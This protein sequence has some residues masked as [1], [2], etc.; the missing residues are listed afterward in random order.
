MGTLRGLSIAR[1]IEIFKIMG[2]NYFWRTPG[3]SKRRI[4]SCVT[5]SASYVLAR[6]DIPLACTAKNVYIKLGID[7]HM[8]GDIHDTTTTYT[9]LASVRVANTQ[10]RVLVSMIPFV[11]IVGVMFFIYGCL[12][13]RHLFSLYAE[14]SDDEGGPCGKFCFRSQVE[15]YD[16][17]VRIRLHLPRHCTTP[18]QSVRYL[19]DGRFL[20]ETWNKAS[21]TV[22]TAL[23]ILSRALRR[24]LHD[25]ASTLKIVG[26]PEMALQLVAPECLADDTRSTTVAVKDDIYPRQELAT[27]SAQFDDEDTCV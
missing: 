21:N 10:W 27:V 14:D 23:Y 22:V 17:S 6:F 3:C 8:I 16:G 4:V 15:L 20:V 18:V 26:E 11:I 9:T 24:K 7:R 1:L 12:R 13:H 19:T 2:S 5:Q 25:S